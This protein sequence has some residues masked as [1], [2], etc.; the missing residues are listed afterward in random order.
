MAG[1]FE[2]SACDCVDKKG[3]SKRIE[4]PSLQSKEK[5]SLK[6]NH[7]M[8]GIA[9]ETSNI[10]LIIPLIFGNLGRKY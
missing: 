10:I 4:S 5:C 9:S 1:W 6:W 3:K 7:H 2:V 8:Q